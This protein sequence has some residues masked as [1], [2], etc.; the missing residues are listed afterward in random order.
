MNTT[1]TG[2]STSTP[3]SQREIAGFNNEVFQHLALTMEARRPEIATVAQFRVVRK[4][5][6]D[7]ALLP[8]ADRIGIVVSAPARPGRF[9]PQGNMLVPA[10]ALRSFFEKGEVFES[11][12]DKELWATAL[13]AARSSV[14]DGES[15]RQ[16]SRCVAAALQI[17][18]GLTAPTSSEVV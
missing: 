11:M 16:L 2:K 18:A 17:R 7:Y 9:W 12:T 8:V 5:D 14:L 4:G 10:D 15:C 1:T 3:L 13:K 6:G